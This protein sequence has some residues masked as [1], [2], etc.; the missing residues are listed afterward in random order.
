MA[1]VVECKLSPGYKVVLEANDGFVL[2]W[3]CPTWTWL[4]VNVN[5][6]KLCRFCRYHLTFA[7][8][9][10]PA[11]C[12]ASTKHMIYSSMES[13]YFLELVIYTRSV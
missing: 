5:K 13:I 1:R 3:L 6:I 4:C 2:L 10:Q 8:W 9:V 7:F 12:V 11:I